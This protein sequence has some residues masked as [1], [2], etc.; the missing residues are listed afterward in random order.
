MLTFYFS[1]AQIVVVDDDLETE[2]EVINPVPFEVIAEV[3]IF[4]GCEGLS[5]SEK[6]DCFSKNLNEF[7]FQNL[8]P[9]KDESGKILEGRVYSI[10][11]IDLEGQLTDIRV[12]GPHKLM[13]EEVVRVLN[14]I[15]KV[16]PGKDKGEIVETIYSLP[17]SF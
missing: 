6:K 9:V 13:E 1:S 12:R 10:F 14:T 3:P 15:T 2:I 17:I 8:Q 4:P 7:I 11:T 5:K 16:E